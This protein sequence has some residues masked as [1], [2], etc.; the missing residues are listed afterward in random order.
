STNHR[1][2]ALLQ[3]PRVKGLLLGLLRHIEELLSEREVKDLLDDGDF[4][5]SKKTANNAEGWLAEIEAALLYALAKNCKTSGVI[6]EIGSWKGKSTIFLAKGS[7]A[8][9]RVKVYAIDPHEG[10]ESADPTFHEFKKNIANARVEDNVAPIVKTS[11]EAAKDFLE[12]CALIFVDGSHEPDSVKQDFALWAP[13][14]IEG[15]I[16]AFHD[17]IG[18]VGPRMLVKDSLYKSN[19]FKNVRFAR[20]ITYGEKV[21][22]NTFVDRLKNRYFL[23]CNDIFAFVCSSFIKVMCFGEKRFGEDSNNDWTNKDWLLNYFDQDQL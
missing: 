2:G 11:E 7:E 5:L 12:P 6:V 3:Q 4:Q 17:T 16:I 14:L 13:K 9:Q 15:G 1:G 8:G 20:T 18:W 21:V 10:G 23:V 22:Q 19:N